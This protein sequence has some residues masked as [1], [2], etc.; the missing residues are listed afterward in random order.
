MLKKIIEVATMGLIALSLEFLFSLAMKSNNVI[1]YSSLLIMACVAGI[2]GYIMRKEAHKNKIYIVGLLTSLCYAALYLTMRFTTADIKP[3]FLAEFNITEMQWDKFASYF[4]LGYGV[5]QFFVGFALQYGGSYVMPICALL[6]GV[7]NILIA[8][9]V[10]CFDSILWLRFAAGVFCAS[11]FSGLCGY[12]VK[13]YRS[14]FTFLVNACLFLTIKTGVLV[15]YIVNKN[16]NS[17]NTSLNWANVTRYTGFAFIAASAIIFAS[18]YLV[19]K[20]SYEEISSEHKS[21]TNDQT[22]MWSVI[23]SEKSIFLFLISCFSVIPFYGL[24]T[25][26]LNNINLTTYEMNNAAGLFVLFIPCL[27]MLFGSPLSMFLTTIPTMVCLAGL[28]MSSSN[29]WVKTTL[30]SLGM[31]QHIH[32]FAPIIVGET[33]NAKSAN[34]MFGLLNFFAMLIGCFVTQ[35]YLGKIMGLIN[36]YSGS[37]DMAISTIML[38]KA[39]L[40]P[41]A[42]CVVLTGYYYIKYRNRSA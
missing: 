37:E 16:I 20:H 2:A 6:A 17:F 33:Y 21:E 29:F 23:L 4:S 27:T 12:L 3:S 34:I 7:C 32:S 30:A 41:T 5:A 1:L 38:I 39:S 25:G 8:S 11:C 24:Q 22:S 10:P 15:S 14:N 42:I 19:S 31:L 13:Y 28:F 26:I 18:Y 36:K 40:I 35:N 9:G